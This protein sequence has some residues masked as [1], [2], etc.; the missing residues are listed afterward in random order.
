VFKFKNKL[1][2]GEPMKKYFVLFLSVLLLFGIITSNSFSKTIQVPIGALLPMTGQGAPYGVIFKQ[3]IDLA[4]SDVNKF[5]MPKN[6]RLVIHYMDS[7]AS[8]SVA[9]N[10]FYTLERLYHCPVILSAYTNVSLAAGAL[11]NRYKILIINAGGQGNNLGR[12]YPY[13]INTI[14]LVEEE[15]K[16]LA[17]YLIYDKNFKTAGILYDNNEGGVSAKDAFIKFFKQYGGEIVATEGAK[18]GSPDFRSPLA[19]I[20]SR[21]PDV[22]Y[23]ATYGEDTAVIANQSKE[24][25]ID[26]PLAENSW[27][28]IPPVINNPNANGMIVTYVNLKGTPKF[29][30]EYKARY[31]SEPQ[32][33]Y[34]IAFY[35][36]VQV[37]AQS[38]KYMV[39]RRM[40]INGENFLKSIHEIKNFTGAAGKFTIRPDGTVTAPVAIGI[41]ENGKIKTIGNK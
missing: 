19:S 24:L 12:A 39:A 26:I 16:K 4:V 5:E 31:G 32:S 6:Y 37:I 20:A 22:I 41:I 25:G 15:T 9:V 40:E 8:T 2:G 29:L 21:H 7:Q 13:L 34:P 17:H 27:S 33:I 11:G 35:N 23:L 18:L 36:A 10:D 28:L 1:F 30:S 14:P 38:L 3:A